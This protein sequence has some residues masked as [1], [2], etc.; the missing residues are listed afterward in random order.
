MVV[1]SVIACVLF[2]GSCLLSRVDIEPKTDSGMPL[3]AVAV[4]KINGAADQYKTAA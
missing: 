4:Y 1:L 3:L 2:L